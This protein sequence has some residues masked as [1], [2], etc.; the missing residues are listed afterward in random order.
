MPDESPAPE[1]KDYLK[2][3]CFDHV[4]D[5]EEA[6]SLQIGDEQRVTVTLIYDPPLGIRDGVPVHGT[7][8]Y[9]AIFKREEHGYSVKEDK[10]QAQVEFSFYFRNDDI[11]NKLDALAMGIIDE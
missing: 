6:Q 4:L 11:Q 8:N 2:D 9:G 5:L 10:S 1:R 3:A 7:A